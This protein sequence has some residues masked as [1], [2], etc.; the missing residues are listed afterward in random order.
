[1]IT[2]SIVWN[3]FHFEPF[4]ILISSFL[5]LPWCA[6][7]LQLE[8]VSI[9][10]KLSLINRSGFLTINSQPQ[11]NGVDS[12]DPV[13][14]WGG[15][16]GVVYQKAYLEFFTSTSNFKKLKNLIELSGSSLKLTYHATNHDGSV[17]FSNS[18]HNG[19]A[20][21]TWGVFPGRE[22]LQ[23]TVV[24]P[25]AFMVWKDEAFS[26]WLEQWAS[27]YDDES[28]SYELMHQIHDTYMLVNV[29]DNN[30]QNGD[31][32]AIFDNLVDDNIRKSNSSSKSSG[33]ERISS[34]ANKRKKKK[35][36]NERS[37]STPANSEAPNF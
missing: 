34:G 33:G 12:E 23:P 25:E 24:D 3:L 21:V 19:T 6:E 13:F 35:K 2:E 8:T 5:R 10:E 20:A 22:V 27:I 7:P 37:K 36:K 15:S 26:L 17:T 31:L 14:G 32:F 18:K 30:F 4:L 16:G 28:L 11:L 1:M 9:I 29:V